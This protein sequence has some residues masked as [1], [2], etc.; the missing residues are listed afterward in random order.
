MTYLFLV[1]NSA[2]FTVLYL[3]FSS[4]WVHVVE[5]NLPVFWLYLHVTTKKDLP[6]FAFVEVFTFYLCLCGT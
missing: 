2:R 1:L 4:T 3:C 5:M 6:K